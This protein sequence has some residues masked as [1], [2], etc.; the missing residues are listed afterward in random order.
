MPRHSINTTDST[1][2]NAPDSPPLKGGHSHPQFTGFQQ[3]SPSQGPDRPEN[4]PDSV[5]RSSS[6]T[7]SPEEL[8]PEELSLEAT[9]CAVGCLFFGKH[10]P[11]LPAVTRPDLEAFAFEHS[12][13]CCDNALFRPENPIIHKKSPVDCGRS[14]QGASPFRT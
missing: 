4:S 12:C 6:E 14:R 10:C 8:S 1:S 11:Q 3:S 2:S 9:D 7:R 5:E 13:F